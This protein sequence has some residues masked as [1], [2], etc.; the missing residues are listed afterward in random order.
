MNRSYRFP[1]DQVDEALHWLKGLIRDLTLTAPPTPDDDIRLAERGLPPTI[2]AFERDEMR[3]D[4][5]NAACQ[6]LP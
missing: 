4:D 5:L 3:R 2:G 6:W 1:Q